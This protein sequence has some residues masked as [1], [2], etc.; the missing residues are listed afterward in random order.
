MIIMLMNQMNANDPP[1][2]FDVK[3]GLVD[4]LNEEY[5]HSDVPSSSRTC[6]QHLF[7][8]KQKVELI[9]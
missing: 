7:S 1:V 2:V 8:N 5:G 4:E 6:N 3:D 9:F